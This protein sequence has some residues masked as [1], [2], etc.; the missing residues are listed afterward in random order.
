ME[1]LYAGFVLILVALIVRDIRRMRRW[2]RE[3]DEAWARLRR[4]SGE[5]LVEAERL[6]VATEQLRS[7]LQDN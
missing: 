7:R 4:K 6:R 1:Y 2:K 5:C 3:E